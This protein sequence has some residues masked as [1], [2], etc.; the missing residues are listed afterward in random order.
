MMS[1]QSRTV[2]P[3]P[4]GTAESRRQRRAGY[5]LIALAALILFASSLVAHAQQ[6]S[7]KEVWKEINSLAWQSYPAVG[8]IG[9]EANIRLSNDIRFLDAPNTNRFV[10]LNENPPV[11]NAYTIAPLGNSEICTTVLSA[12]V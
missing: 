8:V 4:T 5:L 2:R 7:Q 10:Q 6:S 11:N 9:N 12:R 3:G 1:D